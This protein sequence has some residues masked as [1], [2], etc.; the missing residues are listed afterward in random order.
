MLLVYFRRLTILPR[1]VIILIDIIV[2]FAS[3]LIGYLLR[4]NF[5]LDQI[6]IH[7]PA[8]GITLLCS[9]GALS[10]ILTKSYAGIVRYTGIDD[11]A[12]LFYTSL[13]SL[14]FAVIV[15]L[16][17]Y[18]NSDE[19]LIPYSVILIH[20]FVSF[21]LLLYYRLVVK[22]IF[23]YVK[24][25]VHNRV[26]TAIFGAG[27]IGMLTKHA[28]ESERRNR[29][30]LVAFFEDDDNKIGKTVSGVKI[31]SWEDFSRK[32]KQESISELIIAVRNLP[33]ERKN[34]IVEACI[35]HQVKVRIVPSFDK[36]VKGEFKAG[37][38]KD[39]NIDDLLGRDSIQ[40]GETHLNETIRGKVIFV[41]GAAGSIGSELVRQ[42]LAYQPRQLVLID[43]AESPLY[44]LEREIAEVKTSSM[45]SFHL[46]DVTNRDR[47]T[48]LFAEYKPEIVFHAAA[49]K[50]VPVMESNPAEAV[51]CNVLGTKNLADLAVAFKV[52]KFIMISTDKAVN[53]TSVM[54]CSKRIA[55]MYVQA[56]NNH[57]VATG[58]GRTLFVTTR[59]GNV[60]GSNGSVIPIFKKQI[61]A[62]GPIT[63]THPDVIRYFM[64][65]PEACRLVLEAGVMGN[66][67]EIFIFDMG[68]PVRIFDLAKKMVV[69]SGLEP[70]KDID[71]VFTGLR[72]GEKLYEELLND[73]ENTIPTH[74]QKILKAKVQEQSY[75]QINSMIELFNDLVHDKNELK[76]V[77]L[78][79]ELVPEF[80][81]NYSK[82]EVLDRLEKH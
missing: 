39:V 68:K 69:L 13:L 51:T 16:I 46:C 64:T 49:Y 67:G 37:Q 23:M 15:N 43:Q 42:V 20:F 11:A 19:N 55:E 52:R 80:K 35:A 8:I 74:H 62:G 4:F 53:P 71:I 48:N 18:Y 26:N 54:G 32:V 63:V 70:N 38:I 66:G 21:L 47:I 81:S 72:E 76:M 28:L 79:K 24:T 61:E 6:R 2:L 10:I 29:S 78:M 3:A 59:F 73:K 36:W 58:T 50:H 1:W 5:A 45:V 7:N 34:E 17:Y 60:L 82:F 40:L 31:F 12:R 14:C 56:L 65:I 33:T 77:A 30:R 44:E 22:S 25:D 27:Q 75:T 9:F 41:T 57:L